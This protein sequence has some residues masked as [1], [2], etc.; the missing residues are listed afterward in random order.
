MNKAEELWAWVTE[1][2]DGSVGT[3]AVAVPSLP[4]LTPLITRDEEA[5]RRLEPLARLHG[6]VAGQRVWL[7]RYRMVE[8]FE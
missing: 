2:P 3:I 8:D 4:G 1:Y 7:R 5:I 6:K